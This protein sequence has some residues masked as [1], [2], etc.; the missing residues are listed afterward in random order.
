MELTAV[1][2]ALEHVL[3]QGELKQNVVDLYTDSMYVK[4]GITE[5]IKNWLANGWK[6]KAKKPVKN[7]ELW[8]R[9]LSLAEQLEI[10][11]NWTPA[12]SGIELNER[13]DRLVRR[14]ISKML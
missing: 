3:A 6:N 14:E 7:K 8:I 5:W 9:L 12:H 2:R 10:N 1:I 13:C 4:K 11:W